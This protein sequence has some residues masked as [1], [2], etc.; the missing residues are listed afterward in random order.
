MHKIP[1]DRIPARLTSSQY[2]TI[3]DSDNNTAEYFLIATAPKRVKGEKREDTLN[4]AV[5]RTY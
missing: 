1:A 4:T 3:N 5:G 2:N